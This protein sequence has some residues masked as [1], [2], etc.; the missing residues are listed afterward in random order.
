MVAYMETN[1]GGR[2]IEDRKELDGRV[3][4]MSLIRVK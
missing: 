2:L 3:L 4:F 1:R